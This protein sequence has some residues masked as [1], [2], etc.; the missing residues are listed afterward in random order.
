MCVVDVL[1]SIRSTQ[2][3][4]EAVVFEVRAMKHYFDVKPMLDF[5]RERLVRR[6]QKGERRE[7]SE[8][9]LWLK[10][11]ATTEKVCSST[12]PEAH[13]QSAADFPYQSVVYGV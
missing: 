7:P 10:P 5:Y 11:Q 2:Y 6:L 9:R 3:A 8:H 13:P 4:I 12:L 1:R